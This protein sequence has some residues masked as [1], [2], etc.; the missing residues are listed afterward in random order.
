[1]TDCAQLKEHYESYALGA[2]EGAERAELEAH[3]ARKCPTCAAELERARWLVAQLAS[4]APAADPPAR[5]R[6]SI[7]KAVQAPS[8]PESR[9]SWM[10]VWAW[11]GVAALVLFSLYSVRETRRLERKLAA[12]QK[13]IRAEQSQTQALES[14]RQLYQRALAILAA[15]DT[16]EMKLK[17]AG[18][19]ALPEVH[20]YWNAQFGLVV[21]G[22]Q[23]PSPAADRTFQ[24]WV[25]PKKG[26]PVSAGIFRPDAT[27]HVLHITKPEADWAAAAALAITDEPAGGRPQPSTK[28]LWIGPVS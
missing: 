17:P 15:K 25:V 16:R 4:L 24:L 26:S 21:A 19:R 7:L 14:D 23:V 13:Q 18:P 6:R 28:P 1:M 10:H 5:L 2:L 9:H 22:H 27:G 3:L 12:L 8:V 11:V 20:A